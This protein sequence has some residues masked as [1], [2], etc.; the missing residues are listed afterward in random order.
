MKNIQKIKF[1]AIGFFSVLAIVLVPM[2]TVN[3]STYLAGSN[4]NVMVT[5]N[6]D[7]GTSYH[8]GDPFSVTGIITPMNGVAQGYTVDMSVIADGIFKQLLIPQLLDAQIF[9]TISS[10]GDPAL[11]PATA[12]VGLKIS[13]FS[14]GV[15]D[16]LVLVPP[17]GECIANL[18]FVGQFRTGKVVYTGP[19]NHP[20]LTIGVTEVGYVYPAPGSQTGEAPAA[21]PFTMPSNSSHSFWNGMD[22][23]GYGCEFEGTGGFDHAYVSSV[24]PSNMAGGRICTQANP[25]ILP[26]CRYPTDPQGVCWQKP[27]GLLCSAF[28][29]PNGVAEDC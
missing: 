18:T 12:T 24:S 20:A 1:I 15:D 26:G 23:T 7:Y 29:G 21:G 3:A 22:C 2:S 6:L 16:D 9:N 5:V 10:L 19:T 25:P 14:T 11:A 27:A 13:D 28:Q 4:N 8:V 17:S